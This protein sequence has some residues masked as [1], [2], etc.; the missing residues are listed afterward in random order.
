MP[1]V[2]LQTFNRWMEKRFNVKG[3]PTVVDID[4][5][6]R[7]VYDYPSGN[8]D[9]Y[10]QG[11]SRYMVCA[12][13]AAVAAQF[14]EFRLRNPVGSNVVAVIERISCLTAAAADTFLLTAGSSTLD[15]ATIQA[16]ARLDPR[17]GPNPTIIVSNSTSASASGSNGPFFGIAA[18]NT[19]N[20]EFIRY[21]DEQFPI[22]P[23]FLLD[24]KNNA[25][26]TACFFSVLWR[27]RTLETSELT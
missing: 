21:R 10:L 17:A 15:L 6:M 19:A 14:A 5:A 1:S 2:W 23:G 16:P 25:A 27:E 9:S 4:P 18:V 26:N 13:Q 3:G 8:D 24:I 11:W 22:L 12:N 20:T 7:L